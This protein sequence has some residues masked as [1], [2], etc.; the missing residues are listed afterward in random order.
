[1][2]KNYKKILLINPATKKDRV[3][4]PN[5]Y[6][7]SDIFRYP[8]LGTL[9]IAG[10]T[11]DGYE[12]EI[13]DET[14]E[15]ID[16]NKYYD[17][18]GVSAVTALANRAYEIAHIFKSK[19]AHTVI[20]GCHAT[21]LPNEAKQHFDTVICGMG[22]RLWQQFLK[23]FETDKNKCYKIYK[24]PYV[25]LNYLHKLPFPARFIEGKPGYAKGHVFSIMRGCIKKC[26]FCSICA[27]FDKKVYT[28]PLDEALQ[29]LSNL[30]HPIINL[31]DDNIYSNPKYAYEF[32][33]AVKGFKKHW[34]FQASVD[35]IND[36]KL[37]KALYEANAKG[38]FVGF[39][40]ISTLNLISSNKNHNIVEK[41]KKVI[42][43]FHEH[44]IVVEAGMMFGF[45]YDTPDVFEKTFEFFY[46]LGLDLMQI[47][48]VTP[49]PGTPFFEYMKKENRIISYNWDD[50]DCKKVVIK[51][52]NMTVEQL[53]DGTNWL[54][55][56][57]YSYKSIINR[58]IKNF[59]KLGLIG[60]LGYFLRG[61][62]G[63][64]K[65]HEQNLDYPP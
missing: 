43:T 6:K 4:K 60:T 30:K 9:A 23:D 37:M 61:N 46:E 1:M 21:F 26:N 25:P 2:K 64:K 40:S 28:R 8:K 39:E 11:L 10:A 31:V 57:F 22:E 24:M 3:E 16:F 33:N 27:F 52:K 7:G 44:G 58:G 45:D 32:F 15:I 47:A 14:I 17:I 51:P 50:Y 62:L 34:L 63:F 54:R 13:I 53:I 55:K 29:E 35:I 19:G 36:K 18:V 48:V 12:V 49:M 5:E 38:V 41:Y 65:N 56:N 42:D 59:N 20:G